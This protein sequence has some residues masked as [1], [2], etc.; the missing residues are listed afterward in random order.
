[1]SAIDK[2]SFPGF[3]CQKCDYVK[4]ATPKISFDKHTCKKEGSPY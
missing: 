4:E 3:Y 1:M 2:P